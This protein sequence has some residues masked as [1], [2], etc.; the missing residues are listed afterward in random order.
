MTKQGEIKKGG[1]MKS[2]ICPVCKGTGEYCDP[3]SSW[4]DCH[5]CNGRGWIEVHE[6]P[7]NLKRGRLWIGGHEA[8]VDMSSYTLDPTWHTTGSMCGR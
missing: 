2:E 3:P 4:R 1:F 7:A 6:E 5:G 8:P